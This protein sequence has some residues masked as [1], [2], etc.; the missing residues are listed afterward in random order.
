MAGA[1]GLERGLDIIE[2]I[3]AA[4]AP[5]RFNDIAQHLGVSHV[6]ASR[7]LRVLRDRG[8]V[9]KDAV[10]GRYKPGAKMTLV[11][12]SI[13]VVER[14]RR[15]AAVLLP[16]L[17][18]CTRSTILVIHWTGAHMHCIAKQTHP[19]SIA[20]QPLGEIRTNLLDCPWGWLFYQSLD[21]AKRR[22]CWRTGPSEY[23]DVTRDR[24][25]KELAAFARSGY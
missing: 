1:P 12:L 7:I 21:D 4:P 25:S 19:E 2:L 5:V 8:F 13:P 22:Q 11:G 17:M 15:E 24:V 14:L 23:P 3:G 6:S 9:E 16:A 18:E 20:M 10:S